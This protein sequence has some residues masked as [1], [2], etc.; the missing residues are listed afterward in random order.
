MKSSDEIELLGIRKAEEKIE[1]AFFKVKIVSC[2]DLENTPVADA[3]VVFFT[4][5]DRVDQSF[6]PSDYMVK[7]AVCFFVSQVDSFKSFYLSENIKE[8]PFYGSIGPS[9]ES[10]SIGPSSGSMK[11]VL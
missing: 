1:T 11:V 10:G 8:T 4:H 6:N 9:I 7:G 3:D 2:V 5:F